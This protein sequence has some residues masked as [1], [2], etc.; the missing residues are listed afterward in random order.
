[1]FQIIKPDTKVDFISKQK[2]FLILSGLVL[3]ASIA[4][5]LTIGPN[6]GIDFKGGSD[7]ILQFE[8]DVTIK[9][10]T[11]A[12]QNEAG[13]ATPTVQLYGS[14]E[15]NRFMV[16]TQSV[17][18]MDQ[19]KSDLVRDQLGDLGSVEDYEWS[20]E[21]P[22]RAE[23][24]Y[25]AQVDPQS[26]KSTIETVEGVDEVTVTAVG[27]QDVYRYEIRFE[28]LQVQ[29][30]E[31]FAAAFPDKFDAS[32]GL[33]RLETVGAQVGE[34]FRNAGVLSIIVALFFILVYIAFRFDIRYAPGAVAALTHDVIIA[35]GFFV[36]TQM[37]IS[38]PIIAALLTI[39]GYSLNDTIVV[40]DR[41]REN[42]ELAGGESTKDIVNQSLNETMSRTLITSITTLLAVVAIAV[43]GG[44]LIQ[45]F[46][47]ALIVGVIIGT[48][49]SVF[50]ASPIMVKMDAF[51]EAQR[52]TEEMMET[53]KSKTAA[54]E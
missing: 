9:E 29:I 24:T 39:V 26:L 53:K 20:I 10:V 31:G 44:G 40:F 38:L 23:V 33:E 27:L 42:F 28:D 8:G 13:L 36:V 6:Y 34:Q 7:I 50:V 54:T 41:I 45:N 37:E 21:Q 19:E 32:T 48:Y 3:V 14:E 15:D 35:A 18:V 47:I 17:S 4:A 2:G 43:L 5:A 22:S 16:Q 46:A 25:S 49:S 52:E 30:L 11:E 12:A 51:L 1:M